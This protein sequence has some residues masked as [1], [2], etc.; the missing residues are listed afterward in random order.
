MS[1]E[2]PHCHKT[3]PD[4]RVISEAEQIAALRD[5]RIVEYTELIIKQNTA[6]LCTEC[7][8][9]LKDVVKE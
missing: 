8:G 1:I 7:G 9:D 2:C 4:V 6:I 3:I 5:D